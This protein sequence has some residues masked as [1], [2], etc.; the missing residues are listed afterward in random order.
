MRFVT[1]FVSV[2]AASSLTF[3]TGDNSTQQQ[4]APHI[5][6]VLTDDNGWLV[7]LFLLLHVWKKNDCAELIIHKKSFLVNCC[8]CNHPSLFFPSSTFLKLL[9][10]S[11]YNSIGCSTLCESII[12]CSCVDLRVESKPFNMLVTNLLLPSVVSYFFSA[13]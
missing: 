12:F 8:L 10:E 5:I 1:C 13:T 11:I 9:L 6:F 3:V 4:E 7:K 2:V